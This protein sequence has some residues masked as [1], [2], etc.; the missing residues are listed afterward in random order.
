MDVSIRTFTNLKMNIK[1]VIA[2]ELED[3]KGALEP[4]KKRGDGRALFGLDC[5]LY[6]RLS[7]AE[8]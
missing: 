4:L 1:L 7:I 2:Q 3:E 5:S 6:H 8:S